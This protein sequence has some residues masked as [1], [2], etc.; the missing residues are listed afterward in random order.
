[1]S[2][3]D[4]IRYVVVNPT[5]ALTFNVSNVSSEF[6]RNYEVD[7]TIGDDPFPI[8]FENIRWLGVEPSFKPNKRYLIYIDDNIGVSTE[9]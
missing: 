8:T 5:R 4:S 6:V 9:L 2:L 1:M 7:I 3:D